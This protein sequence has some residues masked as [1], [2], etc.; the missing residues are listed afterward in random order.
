M[1]IFSDGFREKYF[2]EFKYL[3]KMKGMTTDGA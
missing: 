3:I 1:G 2:T